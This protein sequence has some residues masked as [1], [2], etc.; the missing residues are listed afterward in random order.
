ME[1]FRVLN[2][3]DSH[4]AQSAYECDGEKKQ[5]SVFTTQLRFTNGESHRQG[6]EQQDHRIRGSPSL[7]EELVSPFKELR[8]VRLVNSV[9]TEQSP[10]EKDLS[11]Q[12]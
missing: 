8:M 9:E 10:E 7:V 11:C 5:N 12:K 3:L 1:F 6:R 4:E 2:V